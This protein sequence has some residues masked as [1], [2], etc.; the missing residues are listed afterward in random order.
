MLDDNIKL[1]Q[2]SETKPGFLSKISS[3]SLLG[4][5]NNQPCT[6]STLHQK[7]LSNI[8]INNITKTEEMS[9][10]DINKRIKDL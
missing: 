10:A 9:L 5:A 3:Y 2:S 8:S 7:N 4:L 6:N 1:K